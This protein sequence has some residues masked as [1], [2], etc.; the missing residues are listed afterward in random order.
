MLKDKQTLEDYIVTMSNTVILGKQWKAEDSPEDLLRPT[1][2]LMYTDRKE[3]GKRSSYYY[4]VTYFVL[5]SLTACSVY[6]VITAYNLTVV[7]SSVTIETRLPS[8]YHTHVPGRTH[9]RSVMK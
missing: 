5:L 8:V 2:L 9:R 4:S 6:S 1:G 7:K 3:V